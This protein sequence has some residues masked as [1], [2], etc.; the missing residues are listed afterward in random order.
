MD[1][2]VEEKEAREKRGKRN[3]EKERKKE[4]KKK[5]ERERKKSDLRI[6]IS[7]SVF[8]N[9]SSSNVVVLQARDIVF[10]ARAE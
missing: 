3:E 9:N 4:R 1:V 5:R 6:L 10:A 2:L 8:V 7:P